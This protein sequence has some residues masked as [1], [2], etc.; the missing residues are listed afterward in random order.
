[1]EYYSLV[2]VEFLQYKL[3]CSYSDIQLYLYTPF[4]YHSTANSKSFNQLFNPH[5]LPNEWDVTYLTGWLYKA[6]EIKLLKDYFM[7]W[8]FLQM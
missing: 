1:M 3:Y 2:W 6:K 4:N 5:P 8:D 7:V